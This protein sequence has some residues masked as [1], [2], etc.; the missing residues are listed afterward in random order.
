M[1]CFGQGATTAMENPRAHGSPRVLVVDDDRQCREMYAAFV[2]LAGYDVDE[3]HNGNQALS[4]ATEDPPALVVTDLALPGLDGYHL[5]ARLREHPDTGHVPIIAITGHEGFVDDT[6]R[7]LGAGCDAILTK[8]CD[9]ARLL[10]EIE[11]LLALAPRQPTT[12]RQ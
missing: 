8:P 6:A 2:R 3:A 12:S 9:P 10:E 11:R 7:A 1:I 4:K 5:A